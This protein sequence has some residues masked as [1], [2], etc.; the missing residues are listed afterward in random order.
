MAEPVPGQAARLIDSLHAVP[1]GQARTLL[2]ALSDEDLA[3]AVR[4]AEYNLAFAVSDRVLIM[5]APGRAGPATALAEA[6]MAGRTVAEPDNVIRALLRM[7]DPEVDRTLFAT[8]TPGQLW[9]I[10][11]AIL[12]DRRGPDGLPVIDAA[13]AEQ[14]IDEARGGH[15]TFEVMESAAI[16]ADP[17]IARAALDYGM[18]NGHQATVLNA[19]A[20]LCEFGLREQVWPDMRTAVEALAARPGNDEAGRDWRSVIAMGEGVPFRRADLPAMTSLYARSYLLYEDEGG[21]RFRRLTPLWDR[22]LSRADDLRPPSRFFVSP[23]GDAGLDEAARRDDIPADVRTVFE[24]RYDRAA[25]LRPR[26][27]LENLRLVLTK[28]DRLAAEEQH[29][30]L[31]ELVRRGLVG[32]TLRAADVVATVPLVDVLPLVVPGDTAKHNCFAVRRDAVPEPA[33]RWA[34]DQVRSAVAAVLDVPG[35]DSAFWTALWR[36]APGWDGTLPTLVACLTRD[37]TTRPDREAS[38]AEPAS[39]YPPPAPEH[40]VRGVDP[41]AALVSVAPS[42]AI[43]EV[44]AAVPADST[45]AG[46]VT[47]VLERSP[48]TRAL[49]DF[50]LGP[51]GM[52]EMRRSLARNAAAGEA[53]LWGLV[54]FEPAEPGILAE[55]CKR[56]GATEDL[57]VAAV[58]RSW[59]AGGLHPAADLKALFSALESGDAVRLHRALAAVLR[60]LDRGHRAI[61]YAALAG[62]GATESVWALELERVGTLAEADETVRASMASGDAAPLL[63]VVDDAQTAAMARRRALGQ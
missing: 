39:G 54:A 41:V 55:V 52:P 59:A 18:R 5:P 19:L 10:R 36:R 33:L 35:A 27:D 14:V 8:K 42:P 7:A 3:E 9:L 60:T 21:G 17:A 58:V 40:P 49:T 47:W 13:I 51:Q 56:P 15:A 53:L 30:A 57:Q 12:C 2:A 46:F 37:L 43:A 4:T 31:G 20:T 24:D 62:A 48:L 1:Y 44:L 16:A 50:A 45:A 63:A 61:A 32:G 22:M 11:R 6:A 28:T 26:P 29:G 23:H 38:S 34:A 25:W